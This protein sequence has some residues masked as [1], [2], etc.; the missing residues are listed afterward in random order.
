MSILS[1]HDLSKHYGAQDVFQGVSVAVAHGEKIALVGPNGAGK[2]TLLRILLGMEEPSAGNVATSRGLR[3]GYLP[4][5]PKLQSERTVYEEMLSLFDELRAQQVALHALTEQLASQPDSAE[6]LERYAADELRFELAGGYDYERRIRQ[7]LGGLGFGEETYAWPIAVLSGGQ[8]T[9]VLLAQLLLRE[10]DLLVLDEPTNYL[11]LA[12][13]EWLESYLAAWPHSLIIVSHDRFFLDRVANR[14]WELDHGRLETFR[15]NYSHYARQRAERD[16]RQA[17]QYQSQQAEIERTEEF[18]RRYKA[19]QRSKQARG[20]ETRL[21][22][23]ERIERPQH[24]RHIGLGLKTDIRSGDKVIVSEE[25]LTIG[26][27]TR[28]DGQHEGEDYCLFRSGPI[29]VQRGDKVAF[30]GPNGTGKTTFVRTLLQEVPPLGGDLRL[31]ASVRLGYLPQKQDWLN[32]ELSVLD[33]ILG[34]TDLLVEEARSLLGRFLFTG[35]DVY[36]RTGDLSGGERARVALA[37]LTLQGANLLVLDEPTTHLDVASQEILQ[38]V[39][40]EFNGTILC[41]THD[42]YLIN[43]LA[44]HIWDVQDGALVQ[45]EG[46]YMAYAASRQQQPKVVQEAGDKAEREEARRARRQ[47]EAQRRK[48][49]EMLHQLEK[50]IERLE[51]D[52]HNTMALMELASAAQDAGRVRELGQAYNALQEQLAADLSSWERLAAALHA[53]D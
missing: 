41:V 52:L 30:L 49:E 24:D 3:T 42:R 9:R 10:P 27:E 8:V 38:E 4:Q 7:V 32:P 18:I 1:A 22:R 45:F 40:V 6:L 31:G 50:R 47:D 2:T 39:L 35:D 17:R 19:G 20:R 43:A 48:Q 14:V 28:P 12:A 37:I 34:A 33:Q 36:K 26:F 21:E 16:E 23:L 25:G 44:T 29:L 53:D 46:D 11:D 13:L 5:R 15:G 51:Q